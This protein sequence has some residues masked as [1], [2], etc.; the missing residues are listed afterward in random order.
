M[1]DINIIVSFMRL[2][3]RRADM[4]QGIIEGIKD[5]IVRG[6]GFKK[7]ERNATSA[8]TKSKDKFGMMGQKNQSGRGM[9]EMLGVLAIIGVLTIGSI[10]GYNYAIKIHR[11]NEITEMMNRQ[12]V[13]ASSAKA[14]G[15]DLPE[16]EWDT[17]AGGFEI[18]YNPTYEEDG[19]VYDNY[20]TI[21]VRNV[22]KDMLEMLI[23]RDDGRAYQILIDGI[24]VDEYDFKNFRR[25]EK[26]SF[27]NEISIIKSAYAGGGVTVTKV[28]KSDLEDDE[29]ERCI[30]GEKRCY[31]G[32]RD[33]YPESIEQCAGNG[34][35]TGYISGRCNYHCQK[36]SGGGCTDKSDEEMAVYVKDP[37][38]CIPESCRCKYYADSHGCECY[39][40]NDC[41][42][43][44]YHDANPCECIGPNNCLC[45]AYASAHT[46]ECCKACGDV[47]CCVDGTC[48]PAPPGCCPEEMVDGCCPDD[49]DCC[50]S[51]CECGCD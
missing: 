46:E 3:Q 18:E 48:K 47:G 33:P 31:T 49:P 50:P 26:V 27:L 6:F 4:K 34:T 41:R 44:T 30:P 36:C 8:S 20:F 29:E 9:V 12:A 39:G 32:D 11:V 22:P 14:I 24:P 17:T 38:D 2:T 13:L 45:P 37:C 21:T 42:C 28:Y 16:D 15:V 43:P 35:W 25:I 10:W 23:K 40:E 51:S 19:V 1:I 7:F 5:R